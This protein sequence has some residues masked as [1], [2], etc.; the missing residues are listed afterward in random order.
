MKFL[1]LEVKRKTSMNVTKLIIR[2]LNII[3]GWN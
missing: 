3:K 2:M 1:I